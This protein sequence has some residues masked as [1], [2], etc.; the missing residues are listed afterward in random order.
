MTIQ[1]FRA[2]APLLALTALAGAFSA[3]SAGCDGTVENTRR[4]TPN[5]PAGDAT[6]D[7]RS[8]GVATDDN[9]VT[10]GTTGDRTAEPASPPAAGRPNDADGEPAPGELADD[11][12]YNATDCAGPFTCVLPNPAPGDRNRIVNPKT[13]TNEWPL[14]PD[15]EIFDGLGGKRGTVTSPTIKINYGQR[16]TLLGA[17]HVYAFAVGTTNGTASSWVPESAVLDSLSSMPTV[18]AR[19]PGKGDYEQVFTITGGDPST[20]GDAKVVPNTDSNNEAATDYMLRNGNVVNVLYALPGKGG[21]SNDTYPAG[22]VKFKRSRGVASVYVY[23]YTKNTST[24]I[25]TQRFIYGHVDGRYGWIARDALAPAPAAAGPSMTFC[26]A[27]C[28]A[29]TAAH[30]VRGANECTTLAKAYCAEGTRGGY[31]SSTIGK[32]DP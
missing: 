21:V 16:K 30:R 18:I 31:E 28:T 14:A 19:D 24:V 6:D 4:P 22:T 23:L 17:P 25:G 11:P 9:E 10:A 12:K 20:Y 3:G 13:G 8:E 5:A 26:C 7:E 27:K 15:T 32:C 2:L 29:R 1:P